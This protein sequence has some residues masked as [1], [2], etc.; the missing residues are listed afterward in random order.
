MTEPRKRMMTIEIRKDGGV[1]N[2]ARIEGPIDKADELTA[3]AIRI[4]DMFRDDVGAS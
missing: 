3:S 4:I 2:V 1:L